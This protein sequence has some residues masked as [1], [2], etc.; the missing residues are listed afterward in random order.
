MLIDIIVQINHLMQNYLKYNKKLN[1]S[2]IY[3]CR[4]REI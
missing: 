1:K 4:F 2:S 3:Y